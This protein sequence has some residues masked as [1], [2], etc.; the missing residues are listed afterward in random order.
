[1][2]PGKSVPLEMSYSDEAER[3]RQVA[4]RAWTTAEHKK[5]VHEMR[6][7]HDV[8]VACL[9]STKETRER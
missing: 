3:L 5:R 6:R 2:A 8:I 7:A 4:W 9:E 1:M